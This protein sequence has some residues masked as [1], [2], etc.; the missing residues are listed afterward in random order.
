MEGPVPGPA[1]E[2]GTLCSPVHGGELQ[3]ISS[4]TR[5]TV[6]SVGL[7]LP[8]LVYLV[9]TPEMGPQSIPTGIRGPLPEG[10][11]GLIIARGSVII[12]DYKYFLGLLM[13]ITRGK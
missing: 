8:S 9:L 3:P 1:N 11:M 5:A 7:H 10:I 13:R 6:R 12:K 4:L 2:S